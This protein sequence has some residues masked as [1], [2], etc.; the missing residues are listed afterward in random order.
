MYSLGVI[1]SGIC[2][3]RED[4]YS[5]QELSVKCP[6]VHQ[7]YSFVHLFKRAIH[8]TVHE[9][10]RQGATEDKSG[11]GPQKRLKPT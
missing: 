7:R 11:S 2:T 4:G 6:G 10:G 1:P 9:V 3:F 5:E 8:T